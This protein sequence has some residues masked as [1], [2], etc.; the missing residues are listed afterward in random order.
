MSPLESNGTLHQ[1]LE[2]KALAPESSRVGAALLRLGAHY[3]CLLVQRDTYF[4]APNGRLKLREIEGKPS[5]LIAYD[6][7][8]DQAQ[9]FSRYRITEIADPQ[10]LIA[11]LTQALGVR[12]VVAKRRKLYLWQD[13]RI[14][15]DEVE[16]LGNYLEFEVLSQ[17]NSCSDWDRMEAL[18]TAFGLR[19]ADSIQA[20]YSDL[21]GL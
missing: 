21:L 5:Q 15:L 12:G 20:S 10:G 17:G 3:E 18:M 16:G 7:P 6:R 11:V 8:E 14:H 1:N 2:L 13:S 9:R 19:D 4:H